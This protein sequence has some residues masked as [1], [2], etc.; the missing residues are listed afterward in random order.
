MEKPSALGSEVNAFLGKYFWAELV[1]R[2][3]LGNEVIDESG[4]SVAHERS[5]R[6]DLVG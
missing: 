2:G 5:Q 1:G 3:D 6:S 4:P